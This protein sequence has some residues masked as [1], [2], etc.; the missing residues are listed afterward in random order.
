MITDADISSLSDVADEHIP[1]LSGGIR[2]AH[3]CLNTMTPENHFI[4]DRHPDFNDIILA[5][6]FSGHG[7]KFA[8]VVGEILADLA[9][10]GRTEYP[11]GFLFAARFA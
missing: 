6:G 1:G 4:L 11:V 3:I 10:D 5:T 9:L 7:F 2:S 8:P